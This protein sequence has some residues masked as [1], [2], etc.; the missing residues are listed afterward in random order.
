M[1]WHILRPGLFILYKH[2]QY[3]YAYN[4]AFYLWWIRFDWVSCVLLSDCAPPPPSSPTSHPSDFSDRISISLSPAKM[5]SFSVQLVFAFRFVSLAFYF[6]P[7]A[8]FQARINIGF[9]HFIFSWLIRNHRTNNALFIYLDFLFDLCLSIVQ[10]CVRFCQLESK[11]ISFDLWLIYW[12][13]YFICS[14]L[15]NFVHRRNR[16]E[17]W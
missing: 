11:H 8:F 14:G 10:L 13:V 5:C 7:F 9:I 2:T 3:L 4:I 16:N 17:I 15:E 6:V 12:K 1:L